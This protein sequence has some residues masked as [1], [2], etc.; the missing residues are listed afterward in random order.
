M[1]VVDLGDLFWWGIRNRDAVGTMESGAVFSKDPDKT[2]RYALWRDLDPLWEKPPL[3][4]IGLNPSTA[5][6]NQDDPTIRRCRG[7]AKRWGHAGLIMLN[8][9]AVRSTDPKPVFQMGMYAAVGP[10]NNDVVIQVAKQ[11]HEAGG[12]VLAAWGAFHEAGGRAL[13]VRLWLK[14]AGVPLYVLG[15]TKDGRP[16]HPLYMKA[17]VDPVRWEAPC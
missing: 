4:V 13:D 2:Y 6:E 8:L 11:V 9:Y 1:N 17:D 10:E 12:R 5:D 14:G 7:F 16:R 15:F 3:V